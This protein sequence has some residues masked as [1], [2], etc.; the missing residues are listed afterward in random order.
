MS[1]EWSKHAKIL[2]REDEE[3]KKA[4]QE[5]VRAA[6]SFK[7]AANSRVLA[8]VDIITQHVIDLSI[9][10]QCLALML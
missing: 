5:E 3:F 2:G 10:K 8:R 4:M 7:S 6:S 9:F 1:E